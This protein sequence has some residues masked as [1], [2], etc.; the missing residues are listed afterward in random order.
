MDYFA[1]SFKGKVGIVSGAGMGQGKAVIK[2]LLENGAKVIAY[3]RSGNKPDVKHENL[4]TMRG[5]SSDLR[6]LTEIKDSVATEY[7]VINFIYNNHGLFSPHNQSF[8]GETAVEFFK[9]NVASSINVIETFLPL[10]N[11]GGSV[12]NVGASPAIF[13]LSSLEYAVS[14]SAVE[15]MTRKMASIL[16]QK[17]IRVNALMPG[18]VDSSREVEEIQP[19]GFKPLQGKKDVS[20]LEIAYTALFLLSDLSYGINGQSI[21]VDG[22]L[23]T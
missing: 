8:H 6:S 1:T 20:T 3:S 21:I 7:G 19:F 9:K 18:S 23:G 11:E 15:E 13:H 22:G 2:L 12:V 10:M 17:N 5:D 4:K 14:K 16:R